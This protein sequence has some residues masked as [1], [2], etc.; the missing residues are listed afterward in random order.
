MRILPAW[1]VPSCRA[2]LRAE[3]TE[4]RPRSWLLQPPCETSLT[5]EGVGHVGPV[6][7]ALQ[8]QLVVGLDIEEEMLVEADTCDQV[9]PVGTFQ[10]APAVDM[11]GQEGKAWL[12]TSLGDRSPSLTLFMS[13]GNE[14]LFLALELAPSLPGI[15][16]HP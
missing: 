11:L 6:D 13:R 5:Y 8:L 16:S 3:R 10:G 4:W 1:Q 9:C 15:I 12:T 7:A 14:L 2:E